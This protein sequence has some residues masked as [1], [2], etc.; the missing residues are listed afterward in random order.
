M[1]ARSAG[2]TTLKLGERSG[3]VAGRHR[4]PLPTW[5]FTAILALA[6]G[7][8]WP[9]VTHL[10]VAPAPWH[11][12]WLLLAAGFAAGQVVALRF[13]F[14][15]E[16]H[17]ATLSEVPLVIGLV[18]AGTDRLLFATVVGT[19]IGVVLRRQAPIKAAFN[20]SARTGETIV[21]ALC[22]HAVLGHHQPISAL[23]WL[24]VIVAV[25]AANLLSAIC[26]QV[27]IALST[28]RFNGARLQTLAVLPAVVLNV[29]V[30]RVT[31]A[32]LW[33]ERSAGVAFLGIA[34]VLGFG[35]R[36]HTG[37]RRRHR[38]L[39]QIYQFSRAVSGLVD[40]DQMINAVL[41]E[42]K[43]LLRAG[44]AELALEVP[45]GVTRYT[46]VG[47]GALVRSVQPGPHP[48][49]SQAAGAKVGVLAP[50]GTADSGLNRSLRSCGFRDAVAVAVLSDEGLSGT[51]VVAN[52]LSDTVTFEGAD[53]QL[54]AALGNHAAMALRSSQLL[55]RLRQEVE[56]KDYQALHDALTGL[57][58][59][60]CFTKQVD[61]ALV[62]RRG[63]AVVAV[64]LM[65]LDRF[66]EVNDTLGHHTGDAMLQQI[67]AQLSR[68]LGD[69]GSVARLG[70]DE[71][72]FVIPASSRASVADV[73]RDLLAGGQATVLV[74]GLRLEVRA[75]L[76][77]ALVPDHGSDRSTLLRRADIAMYHAK[78]NGSGI[79]FYQHERDPH[80]TRR[81][82]LASEL[83]LALET[84]ALEL[85]YQ[86]QAEMLTGQVTGVEALLRWTHPVYGTIAPD[87]FIPL[88]EQ[89]GL[90]R[91]LTLWAFEVGLTQLATWRR[92]G[93]EL[94]LAV[95]L[96]ARSVFD[97]ELAAELDRLLVKTQLPPGALILEIT[98][99][100][101]F[102]DRPQGRTVLD[103]L[104]EL[105]VRLAI[106]DFGTGF[107]SLSRLERLP[108]HEVKI[109]RSFVKGMLTNDGHDAIV[110]STIDLARNLRLRV[111]AEGVEN[112]RTWVR[113]G[114]L[115]CD[116]GQG[117]Y[118]SQSLRAS[119]LASWLWQ[120]QRQD[121]AVVRPLRPLRVERPA[122]RGDSIA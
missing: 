117:Y 39:E 63:E 51:L 81:L 33:T 55:D 46:L 50:R 79:E 109:D 77:V 119:E 107:S 101:I 25:P 91:Q 8:S 31:V 115:G 43:A 111:V 59:R 110:R 29:V 66:K 121:L 57:G 87:E 73:A 45:G 112:E 97:A 13:E 69:R 17:V 11:V 19:A 27:A 26:V 96:S 53:L 95:N 23:G 116:A 16:A 118:L 104:A 85:H 2:G 74:E 44:L 58:N 68:A 3:G 100:S 88:A 47:D 1:R 114:Q 36:V 24:A 18:F 7:A 42:A 4:Q 102:G 72:A 35:Y 98:E 78:S 103:H 28:G 93:L 34:V 6:V 75:S 108:V 76:G 62:N 89:C 67:A 12:P 113:L 82:V 22:F 70:G 120:Y 54:L 80:S 5:V 10:F 71:F 61:E 32:A 83:S 122:V 105:G 94:T 20:L 9:T 64:M 37:L 92:E 38:D 86:P 106:D 40:A 60:T 90:I 65:D 15:G 21:A 99:S 14:S 84:S 48:L 41:S 49:H 52:R 30:G 56:A